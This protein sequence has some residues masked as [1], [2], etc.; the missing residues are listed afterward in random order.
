AV[1]LQRVFAIDVFHCPRCGGQRR[2]V[3]VH[4]RAETLRPLLERLGLAVPAAV[5]CAS[6]SP[7]AAAGEQKL[8]FSALPRA[9]S[10]GAAR[11]P[12]PAPSPPL[13]PAGV[14]PGERGRFSV[15]GPAGERDHR[16]RLGGR[17]KRRGD[18][19]RDRGFERPMLPTVESVI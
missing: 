14:P 9:G 8:L 16:L 1:L 11:P 6:R 2:I 3:A 15:E 19:W 5:P 18:G 17:A 7:P 12:L 13:R 10:P 4:T